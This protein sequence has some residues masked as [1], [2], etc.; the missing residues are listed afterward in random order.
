MRPPGSR[1]PL[2]LPDIFLPVISSAT[3]LFSRH[4]S[5]GAGAEPIGRV[6]AVDFY[7]LTS[8]AYESDY[9]RTP[10]LGQEVLEHP[11][12]GIR[13]LFAASSFYYSSDP[14]SSDIST[15][16]ETKLAKDEDVDGFD[17]VD[18]RFIWNSFMASP[19]L[20]FRTSLATATREEFDRQRFLVL[21]IQGYCG[22]SDI[23][24]GGQPAT[25]SLISRIGWANYG[26]RFNSRGVDDE[27][28]GNVANFVEVGSSRLDSADNDQTE[29]I[30][31]T[32][33]LC[34]SFVQVRGSV[35]LFWEEGAQ[36]FGKITVTR[37]Q[38]A[39]LPAFLRHFESL[40]D[41]YKS[42]HL[43][44]LLSSKDQEALLTDAYE[45]HL[46]EAK[47]VDEDIRERVEMTNFD[48]HARSRVGGIE[49]VKSQLA[50]AIGAVSES[51]GSCLVGLE[52]GEKGKGKA[53]VL[54]GQR[55]VFRTNCK[56]T[57]CIIE[58]R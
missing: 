27:A 21:A 55:G 42:L 36:P 53:Q 16:L 28:Q 1:A 8:D 51:F 25:L 22:V 47:R 57:P 39:S 11:C 37:P 29:T 49:S 2:T 15:R 38:E 5:S 23:S 17:D 32:A 50:S 26:T 43:V 45:S 10:T 9:G 30:L 40:I 41:A 35:P 31:R 54:V 24:L 34:L 46:R 6:L 33:N 7:C 58:H 44:N 14:S 12:A 48:F 13:R 3:S 18:T 19:L 4:F 56:G 52:D 20:A